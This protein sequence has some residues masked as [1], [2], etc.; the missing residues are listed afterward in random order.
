MGKNF[1]E[2]D[3]SNAYL[4]AATLQ[5]EEACRLVLQTIIG[6]EIK[7]VKVHAEHTVFL[8]SD[9]KSVRLDIYANDEVDVNYTVEMQNPKQ[10]N[11]AKRVRYYQAETDV[12]SLK[13]GE[14][15]KHLKPSY[16][17]FICTFDPFGKG[18]Y[19]YT[20]RSVCEETD[21]YLDNEICQIFI[22]TKGTNAADVS[23]ELVHFLKYIEN[24]TDEVAKQNSD[25]TVNYLHSRVQGLKRNR[26][27]E[28]GYMYLQEWL[29]E[30]KEEGREEGKIESKTEDILSFLSEI[31][32]IPQDI[33]NR[34]HQEKDMEILSRWIKLAA[35]ANTIEE[36]QQQM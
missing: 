18:L 34:I 25:E 14:D 17:I 16:V 6:K 8:N 1:Q 36:F 22:S 29:D 2:L 35:R 10:K 31:G 20:F 5:D 12:S 3:L 32:E 33:Q 15:Y 7:K 4:F 23:P 30:Q 26:E 24:S 28:V 21:A 13:P 11:L 9:F 19:R 27:M